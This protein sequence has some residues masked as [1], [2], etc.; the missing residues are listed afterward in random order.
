MLMLLPL[1]PQRAITKG[2]QFRGSKSLMQSFPASSRILDSSELIIA[3]IVCSEVHPGLDCSRPVLISSIISSHLAYPASTSAFFFILRSYEGVTSSM[4]IE[5]PASECQ[6][7]V[8]LAKR[9]MIF[10]EAPT[11]QRRAITYRIPFLEPEP[12]VAFPSWPDTRSAPRK[13]TNPSFGHISL[14]VVGFPPSEYD[15]SSKLHVM[16]CMIYRTASI[17]SWESSKPSCFM[18]AGHFFS[19]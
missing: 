1:E 13:C 5:K 7:A 18:I 3:S 9:F 17:G 11:L 4:P 14:S 16:P 8:N 6:R 2:A 10:A 15:F 12:S 19:T